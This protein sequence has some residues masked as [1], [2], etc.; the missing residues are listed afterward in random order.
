MV[1]Y[2]TTK[3]TM[4]GQT[5]EDYRYKILIIMKI[6]MTGQCQ[7]VVTLHAIRSLIQLCPDVGLFTRTVKRELCTVTSSVI[8]QSQWLLEDLLYLRTCVST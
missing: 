5:L 7:C 2:V 1:E 4:N 3:K 6:V 8:R